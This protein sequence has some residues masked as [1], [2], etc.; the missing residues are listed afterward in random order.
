MPE[1]KPA[2]YRLQAGIEAHHEGGGQQR[3]GQLAQRQVA[4]QHA[5]QVRDYQPVQ[6]NYGWYAPE[7]LLVEQL[8]AQRVAVG[9]VPEYLARIHAHKLG[10]EAQQHHRGAETPEA[11]IAPFLKPQQQQRREPERE[12]REPQVKAGVIGKSQ[13]HKARDVEQQHQP[14]G[15]AQPAG[16]GSRERLGV[17]KHRK[18]GGK[19]QPSVILSGAQDDRR[20]EITHH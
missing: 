20:L 1:I 15:H 18:E 17:I 12:W 7:G 11:G 9:V 3:A 13:P 6:T 5:A 2:R 14:L 19:H 8:E 16:T 4:R 10:P